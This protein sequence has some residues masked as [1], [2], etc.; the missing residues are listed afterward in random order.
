MKRIKKPVVKEEVITVEITHD[1]FADICARL[2]A[3]LMMDA[4]DNGMDMGAALAMSLALADFSAIL[5][6]RLFDDE[7]ETEGEED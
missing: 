3:E 2:C 6:H 7:E 1:E 5:M 4:P